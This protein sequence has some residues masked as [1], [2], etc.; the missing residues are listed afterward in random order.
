MSMV[1][2]WLGVVLSLGIDNLLVSTMIGLSPVR[3]KFKIALIFALFEALM[4]LAGFFVGTWLLTLLGKWAFYAGIVLLFG[5]GVYFLLEDDDDEEKLVKRLLS[6]ASSW[7][8]V[9]T[10]LLISLDEMFVGSSIGLIGLPIGVTA[11]LLGIQAFVFSWLGLTFA[12]SIR[13]LLGEFAEKLAGLL[14]ILLA[15]G[16]LI[17]HFAA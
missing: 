10:G 14:L 8:I 1:W 5:L 7:A 9:S 12:K 6:S 13:P 15:A 4:P 16:L 17:L 3:G 2:M 11:L